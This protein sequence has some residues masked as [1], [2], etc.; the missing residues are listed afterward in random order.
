MKKIFSL[1]AVVVFAVTLPYA[2][3]GWGKEGHGM[4]A[5]IA[6]TFLD[7]NT[8]AIVQQYLGNTTIEQASVW[9]DEM[10]Q[11][12][13]YDYMKSWHYVNIEKGR[14]YQETKDGNIVNALNNAINELKNRDKLSKDDVKKNLMIVF[15]LAGDLHMPLH[16][17][18]G[19][20]KGGN[21][22]KVKY[23]GKPANLHHVW[24]TE[25]IESEHITVND[26]LLRLSSFSK[27]EIDALKKID[28]ENWIH[29]PRSL[30]NKVYDFNDD[31]IDQ[32]YVDKN[33]K[34]VETQIL[35]AG[36]RLS[37][38]LTEVFKS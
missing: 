32:A 22:V 30:L 16:I 6:F 27:P 15:H 5:E 19:A 23:L 33:K 3:F 29:E 21:D 26:C 1:L 28:V 12:H 36:I 4:V 10:R 2:S 14:Q 35:I 37:A 8:K 38:I 7:S 13:T 20:D 9:M 24:D 34:I 11:D 17:G 18:Y 31:I 25:M